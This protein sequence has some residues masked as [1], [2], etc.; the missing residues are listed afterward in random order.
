MCALGHYVPAFIKHAAVFGYDCIWLD[1]EHRFMDDREVQSLLAYSHLCDIDIMVRPAT[2]E[3]ARLYRYLEDGAAGL[4]IPHVSTPEEAYDLAQAVKFPPIGNR[5]L[6]GAGLDAEF[7]HQATAEYVDAANKETFLVVQI[8]TPLAV[9][10]VDAIAA[11]PGVDGMF[12]GPSDLSLRIQKERPDLDLPGCRKAVADAAR[13][14][15]KAWGLPAPSREQIAEYAKEGAQLLARGGDYG[16][17]MMMLRE[18][19]NEFAELSK[20]GVIN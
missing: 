6:D 13:R 8:E 18:W 11:T 9:E 14:H 5:G 3:R 1:L 4:M 15:H 10:N 12:V 20:S 2:R 7:Y 19:S 17:I 16:A